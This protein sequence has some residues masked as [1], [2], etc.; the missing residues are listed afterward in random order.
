L[1]EIILNNVKNFVLEKV[2]LTV[3]HRETLAIVGETG[4]GKTTLIK[5]IAGL[6]PYQGYILLDGRDLRTVPIRD[7]QIG[8]LPQDLFLFPHMTVFSNV[9]AGLK[10]KRMTREAIAHRTE[11]VMTLLGIEYLAGR[12]PA[13]LSGG[14]KQ[15]VALAR[16][17]AIYPDVLLLDE[18]FS[19]LDVKTAKYLRLEFKRV[20]HSLGLTTLFIT[21]NLTEAEEIGDRMAVMDA[22]RIVQTGRFSEAFVAPNHPKVSELLGAYSVLGCEHAEHIGNGLLRVDTGKITIVVPDEQREVK[23]I[24]IASRHVYLSKAQ[25][26]GPDVNRFSG[27]IEKIT[28]ERSLWRLTVNISGERIVAEIAEGDEALHDLKRGDDVYV[29]LRLRHL[30]V[31]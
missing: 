28:H 16:A 8:Y 19:S 30:R 9:A 1:A 14:E 27:V 21:H 20:V 24:A 7:R 13:N 10:S 4:A 3:R 22:G 15:R 18:P 29:I 6:T 17:I 31:V 2:N 11:E 25:P 12:Y 5:T 23:K 26:P